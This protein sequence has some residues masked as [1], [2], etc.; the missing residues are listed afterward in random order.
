MV[1]VTSF[2]SRAMKCPGGHPVQFS[3]AVQS[4]Q[5]RHTTLPGADTGVLVGQRWQ[6]LPA[7][8]TWLAG[9]FSQKVPRES[10]PAGHDTHT[11][12]D[13]FG[14]MVC[15]GQGRQS[16]KVPG[17]HA[18]QRSC[19]AVYAQLPGAH[20][21]Q[22]YSP[23]AREVPTGH[24]VMLKA[25]P[26]RRRIGTNPGGGTRQ[27]L[28][29]R[30]AY[31]GHG[32]HAELS[33]AKRTAMLASPSSHCVQTRFWETLPSYLPSPQPT[34]VLPSTSVSPPA[35]YTHAVEP[36]A[37]YMPCAPSQ[38]WSH[39][40]S[41]PNCALHVPAAHGVHF[42]APLVDAYVPTP[43]VAHACAPIPP[44]NLPASHAVHAQ[45]LENVPSGHTAHEV[46]LA[47]NRPLPQ[48]KQ[49]LPF[50]ATSPAA[51]G[52]QPSRAALES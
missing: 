7:V 24:F 46:L 12:D 13:A 35:Q 8:P 26:L 14:A 48:G 4:G 42:G 31:Q 39:A 44:E 37:L 17:G 25:P 36:A 5:V 29:S 10:V 19:P 30:F 21:T 16:P 28:P 20:G 32:T 33:M 34:H 52:E 27:A 23:S 40:M 18:S 50:T 49:P 47:A 45:P 38:A 22:T 2:M 43:H 1:I 3:P 41:R 15:G 51:H 6:P 11:A 9:Q